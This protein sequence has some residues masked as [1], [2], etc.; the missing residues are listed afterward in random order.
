MRF[1][2][3]QDRREHEDNYGGIR[4][5][6]NLYGSRIN[7]GR[8]ILAGVRKNKWIL[9]RNRWGRFGMSMEE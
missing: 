7:D 2:E 3:W 6:G 4:R 1:V 8:S 5:N 9:R